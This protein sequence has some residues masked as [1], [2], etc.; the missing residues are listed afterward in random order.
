[1]RPESSMCC[2][3]RGR[4]TL[5]KL[6]VD[7]D[8]LQTDSKAVVGNAVAKLVA[9]SATDISDPVGL[10]KEIKPLCQGGDEF[11][12][13]CSLLTGTHACDD[14]RKECENLAYE[15]PEGGR[16]TEA[17]HRDV[18]ILLFSYFLHFNA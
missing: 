14:A 6:P 10:V 15:I 5:S 13:F 12:F 16:T 7:C 9:G 18:T 11:D 8:A 17:L 3:G 1:M 2:V 4:L